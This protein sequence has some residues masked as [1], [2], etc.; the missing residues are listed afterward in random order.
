MGFTSRSH[1]AGRKRQGFRRKTKPATTLGNVATALLGGAAV[2]ANA[3]AAAFPTV[4]SDPPAAAAALVTNL[5]VAKALWRDN[6]Q[7]DMLA[8]LEREPALVEE[9]VAFISSKSNQYSNRL[10]GEKLDSYLARID[11]KLVSIVSVLLKTQSRHSKSLFLAA[12]S[13]SALRQQVPGRFWSDEVKQGG[14]LDQKTTKQLLQTMSDS[15]PLPNFAVSADITQHCVDQCHMWQGT[16]PHS[17]HH[18]SLLGRR[19]V[20]YCL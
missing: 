14:L 3:A 8:V 15:M 1:C 10:Q 2:A 6:Y 9:L 12:K 20:L 16:Y 18:N 17:C 11:V 19:V 7:A 13:V 4:I 5:D